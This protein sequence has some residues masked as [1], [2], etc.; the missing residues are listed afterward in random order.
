MSVEPLPAAAEAT[1]RRD[2]LRLGDVLVQQHLISATQLEEALREQRSSG[3]KLG[4]LFIDSGLITEE[5]LAHA[6]ARQLRVPAVNLKSFPLKSENVRLLAESPARRHRAVVLEDKGE[7]LLVGMVDPLD[8]FAFDELTRL[9]KRP[10]RIAVVPESQLPPVLDRHY[11]RTEEISGLAKALE[12]DIGD[13]VDFGTLQANVGQEAAP[14]VRLLQSVFEDAMQVGASDVHIDPQENHLVIRSRID[15]LL[16]TQTQA[17]KRIGAALAQR[18]KLM[19]GLDISEKRLPQDGRF[20]VRLRERTVDVRLSTLPSQYGESLVM[21]LLSQGD[22]VRRLH[23][24]GMPDDILARLREVLGRHAGML[25][26]TGP[27]GSGKT[28][29]LYAALAELDADQQKIITVEDPIEYRLPGLTQVQ[30]NDRIELDFARVLRAALR[31]D[32]DVILVGEMRDAE[33]VEIGLRSAI[34]GHLVLS[35]LHTRDA[36]GT[37]FRLLDMGAPPFMVATS[38]Q[39]VIA[40]RLVRQ[41]CENCA[42]PTVLNAQESAWL[43]AVGGAVGIAMGEKTLRGQG[44]SAC[45]GTGCSGRLGVYELLEMDAA[46]ADAV[47]HADPPSFTRLARERMAGRTLAAR[48]FELVRQGRVSVAEA[49]RLGNDAEP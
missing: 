37:P 21:R 3:K 26:V 15:G 36:M 4:R 19:A 48:A 45:N 8:L 30:V 49:M 40:Q 44:C 11:R 20:T 2:K 17:E 39:A 29:T 28:T 5:A 7:H 41:N 43:H 46:L 16:Q 25:I 14:V 18:L 27:T 47:T 35:S 38:L 12:R 23:Q 1:P 6:L 31:Q 34:T 22:A 24:I 42:A 13:A 33:T 32:P 9:L 10:L